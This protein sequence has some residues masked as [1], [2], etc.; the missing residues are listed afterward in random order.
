MQSSSRLTVSPIAAAVT[1]ALY[2][3]AQAKVDALSGAAPKNE[4]EGD[5]GDAGEPDGTR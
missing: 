1:A 2:P 4:G 3:G 5:G